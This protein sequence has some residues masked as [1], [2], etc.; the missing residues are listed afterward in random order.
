LPDSFRIG[1][2]HVEPSLHS[3]RGPAGTV[4]LEAKVMQVLLC[5]AEH[6]D[7]V[8]PKERLISAVWPDT[9][10]SDDVLT[11]AISELRR[12]FGD[13]IKNPRF[14]QTIPKSGYR[15]MAPVSFAS[16]DAHGAATAQAARTETLQSR[17]DG[18]AARAETDRAR[19][20]PRVRLRSWKRGL[21]TMAV[22]AAVLLAGVVVQRMATPPSA[23]VVRSVQLTFTG[24][25]TW[26]DIEAAFF[27]GLATDGGRV[28]YTQ[29]TG[30]RFTVAQSSVGGG[31]FVTIRTPFNHALLLH[32]SP[33]GSRLLVR[34]FDWAQQEGPLWVIPAVGGAPLRL[35]AVVAH[36]GAWSPDGKRVVFARGDELYVAVSDGSEPRK[37]ATT[38]GQA[39]WVR[40]SPDGTRLR[41]TVV[42]PQGYTRSLWEV[43]AEGHGLRPVPLGR[44]EYDLDCCGEWSPDG[45]QFFFRRFRDN[46]ADIWASGSGRASSAG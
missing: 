16:P 11:R 9:F 28:Y 30:N 38:P 1:E 27:P 34:D 36:D 31:E 35:G 13:D 24:Q 12:V 15:L 3:V 21:A 44:R 8:V 45:R 22:L 25:V 7:Q 29:M 42:S 43:S 4:R 20:R 10:V 46:R 6:G 41:F 32:V 19:V 39:F 26:P 5:L 2:F 18:D 40:W 17:H 37:L 14:I 33:D 23:R